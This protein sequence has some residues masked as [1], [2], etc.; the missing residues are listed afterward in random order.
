M[1]S[2]ALVNGAKVTTWLGGSNAE[3][4]GVIVNH[5]RVAPDYATN[6]YQN[7]DAVLVSSLAGL[8]TPEAARWAL[9]NVYQSFN[10]VHFA[11]G[12]YASPGERIYQHGRVY[13]YAP[14]SRTLLGLVER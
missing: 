4:N 2:T 9:G 8:P 1:T 11:P 7:V 14:F 3:P 6:L 12:R 10:T 5:R 13:L